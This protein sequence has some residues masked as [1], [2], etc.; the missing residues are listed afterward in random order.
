M[1]TIAFIGLGNMGGPMAQNLATKGREVKGFDL[2][3]AAC[4]AVSRA[5]VVIVDSP[6]A[7]VENADVVVTM[8]PTGQHV[9]G[10]WSQLLPKARR[11]ALF[12]DSSTID[13]QSARQAHSLVKQHGGVALDAP[14]SGGVAG[15]RDATLTFMVGGT[16]EA[17]ALG[18][19][20]LELL[21]RRIVHC[22]GPGA[23]QATKICNNMI[24]GISM[25]AVSEAFALAER[26]GIAHEALFEVASTSS[27]QCWALT[28]YCPV[29]GLV[30]KSPANNDYKPGFATALMLKDLRLAQ[31]VALSVG[32]TTPLG[33]TA[34]QIYSMF[35]SAGHG[36]ED[37]SGIVRFLRDG[38]HSGTAD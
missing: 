36:G 13:V 20:I 26:L 5:G 25:I 7:A 8:L 24:T 18:K 19:P 28:S 14:V 34:T 3:A 22:G 9:L 11:G 12:I 32:A 17:F 37:F 33:A 35:A 31:E 29:P 10:V 4:E 21:G 16:E 27:G 30:P 23:G 6:E 38:T 2:S 15:A 1:N